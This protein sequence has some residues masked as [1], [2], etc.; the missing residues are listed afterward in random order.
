MGFIMFNALSVHQLLFYE[1]S[2]KY[3][4]SIIISFLWLGP[5][6]I[7]NIIGDLWYLTIW[8]NKSTPLVSDR[9]NLPGDT[10]PKKKFHSLTDRIHFLLK[11][12]DNTFYVTEII[13][14]NMG[15]ARYIILIVLIMSQ[16]VCLSEV[17]FI[18]FVSSEVG[19]SELSV[20]S[21]RAY[22]F[23]EKRSHQR[24][25]VKKGVLRNFTKVYFLIK[26]QY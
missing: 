20:W 25:S 24:C 17:R 7:L 10:S 12:T 6:L 11:Y 9:Q 19:L 26:I 13:N 22:K 5:I 8:P 14:Y 15:E 3:L 4:R 23:T 21:S 1:L 18:K 2:F 16:M